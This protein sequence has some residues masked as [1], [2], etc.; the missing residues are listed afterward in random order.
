MFLL[1]TNVFLEWMLDRERADDVQALLESVDPSAGFV[2]L[3]PLASYV[4]VAC[5]SAREDVPH[6]I[7]PMPPTAAAIDNAAFRLAPVRIL[8]CNG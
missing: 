4:Y 6:P 5:A 8:D 2:G 3:A 1:D 7:N